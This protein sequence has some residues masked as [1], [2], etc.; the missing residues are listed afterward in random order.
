[1]RQQDLVSLI[2]P[3]FAER[4]AWLAD[5]AM[6]PPD[7]SEMRF[8]CLSIV[9]AAVVGPLVLSPPLWDAHRRKQVV[10]LAIGYTAWVGAGIT[11]LVALV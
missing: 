3:G 8:W 5:A 1:M 6:T 11:A 2:P 7:V 10:G 4:A 9:C